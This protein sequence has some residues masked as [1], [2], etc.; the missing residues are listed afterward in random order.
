V[1][2]LEALTAHEQSAGVC[3]DALR[4]L[5]A[6]LPA[7][8]ALAEQV[9]A[10][11]RLSVAQ[12]KRLATAAARDDAPLDARALAYRLGMTE[13]QDRLLLAGESV[14][15]LEGWVIPRFPLKGGAI[16]ARGVMAGPEVART[17]RAVESRWMAEG[18]PDEVRVAE[19]L[20]A[21]LAKG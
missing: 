19:L 5:A 12:R 17:L 1:T 18:F 15:G 7:A 13:A 8:T 21:E 10:R 6:L 2:G 9:A 4:R 14:A 16:V 11:L 20:D 3:P